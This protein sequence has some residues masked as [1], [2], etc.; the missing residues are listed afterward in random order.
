MLDTQC[1]LSFF[2]VS[3]LS[4]SK[5]IDKEFISQ[6]INPFD[7]CFFVETFTGKNS[8]IDIDGFFFYQSYRKNE[9]ANA[10]RKSGG[11]VAYIRNEYKNMLECLKSDHEDILWLRFKKEHFNIDKD[12]YLAV[13]YVIPENSSSLQH[14]SDCFEILNREVSKFSS[15]GYILLGGD[16]N[17]RTGLMKDYI[18]DDS[19]DFGNVDP[20]DQLDSHQFRYSQDKKSN[21]AGKYL[22]DFCLQNRLKILN[23]RILGDLIGKFTC[24]K[25]NGNS[26]VDYI[27]ISEDF[28]SKVNYFKVKPLTLFSDHCQIFV[29]LN[30]SP[31]SQTKPIRSKKPKME[32]RKLRYKWDTASADKI[33][34]YFSE[35]KLHEI[36]NRIENNEDINEKIR[37]LNKCFEVAS[38]Q[39]LKSVSKRRKKHKSKNTKFDTDCYNKRKELS[40]IGNMLSK[41]P[42]NVNL[43]NTFHKNK[44]EYKRLIKRKQRE[45]KENLLKKLENLGSKDIKEKWDIIKDLTNPVEKTNSADKIEINKWKEHFEKTSFS[46]DPDLPYPKN[47]ESYTSRL[48]ESQITE[49]NADLNKRFTTQEIL[50]TANNLKS[51]KAVG[52]DNI[53][54]ELIKVF[55]NLKI[56]TEIFKNTFDKILGGYPQK[57]KIGLI[58]PIFKSGNKE[59]PKNYRGITLTSCLGKLFNQ[60]LA[61]RLSNN[62]EKFGIFFD[63]LLGFRPEMR[64][65]NNVFILKTLIDKHLEKSEKLHCCFVDFSKAFDRVWREAML[66]KLEFYGVGGKFLESIKNLYKETYS[67]MIIG[68]KLG[69]SF[70]LNLGVKQGDPLSSFLFN[71][72]MNH[73]CSLLL[74]CNENNPP[75]IGKF[76]IPCLFWADDVVLIS[77]SKEGLQKNID[78]VENYCKEYKMKINVEKTYGMIFNKSG[79]VL[80][81]NKLTVDKVQ[82]KIKKEMKYLGFMLDCNGNFYTAIEDLANKAKRALYSIYK[83]ST[84]N[85]LSISNMISTFNAVI[86]P[87]LLYGS[88]LWGYQSKPCNKIELV[89]IGFAKHILGVHRKSTNLAVLGELGLYPLQLEMKNNAIKYYDYI[90]QN[91]N[92]LLKATLNLNKQFKVNKN[93]FTYVSDIFNETT[94]DIQELQVKLSNKSNNTYDHKR[95]TRKNNK[96]IT[97]GVKDNLIEKF[98][99]NFN[100]DI[101]KNKKLSL[102]RSIKEKPKLENYLTLVN[103]RQHR[104]ALTRLLISAH[105]LKIET[106]RYA[107][108]NGKLDRELRFCDFC[109]NNGEKIDDELHFIFNCEFN[110]CLRFQCFKRI[111]VDVG[112]GNKDTE[113]DN[114]EILKW[115]LKSN[116]S[117][118][119]KTFAKFIF[120]SE[121]ARMKKTQ[122]S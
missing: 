40:R 86:K 82:I 56:G 2:N 105:K 45:H 48:T 13:V 17:S 27:I 3:G 121:Q 119:L 78:I 89:Q 23:G 31:K 122:I 32:N 29:N 110:E 11:I 57:W 100:N 93:W 6:H 19:N 41:N 25:H 91:K 120:D 24:F 16:F 88:E 38:N 34:V 65:T 15:K 99:N 90:R 9:K 94:F 54:N 111:D 73:L 49:L 114:L 83:L 79:K 84:L 66:D 71:V 72:E 95:V 7:F 74:K 106:G 103:C 97:K 60:I 26:T 76:N 51:N 113:K 104:S 5:I 21:A 112:R 14:R 18:E 36:K 52:Y 67:K 102:Y 50:E 118:K 85:T 58:L 37:T 96:I 81:K 8:Q 68:G 47:R 20:Y 46:D 92:E 28:I 59:E 1:S 22:I 98:K 63:N 30:L 10:K 53:S 115:I 117:M 4:K 69:P 80:R 12:L 70:E 109:T 39:C 62:F 42:N 116:D 61:T 108:K 77:K 75:S 44:R 43:R 64:T 55:A 101:S 87:I 33:R 35:N 107:T